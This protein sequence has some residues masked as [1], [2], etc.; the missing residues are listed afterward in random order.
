MPVNLIDTAEAAHR[1]ASAVQNSGAAVAVG[2]GTSLG[3]SMFLGFTP[4]Q[5]Q[6]IGV[7][8][9]LLIGLLGLIGNLSVNAYFQHQRLKMDRKRLGVAE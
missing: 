2:S 1:A 3:L 4:G 6:V 9:G 7:A 5:W 8:G